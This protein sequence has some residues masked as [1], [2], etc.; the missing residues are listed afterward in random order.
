M[1]KWFD[2]WPKWEDM[3][4]TQRSNFI[5]ESLNQHYKSQYEWAL[6]FTSTTGPAWEDLT[7]EQRENIRKE[8]TR[9]QQE[10]QEFGKSLSNG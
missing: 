2:S 10:M 4:E 8:V 1:S 9:H 6:E 3:T 5:K 7:E